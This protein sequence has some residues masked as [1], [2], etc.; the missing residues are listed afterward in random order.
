MLKFKNGLLCVGGVDFSC[1][2]DE[3]ALLM[4][5][6][7]NSGIIKSHKTGILSSE[8]KTFTGKDFVDWC[9]QSKQIGE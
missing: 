8:K 3:Y 9:V 5:A 7:R 2:P 4:A 1:E 6:I